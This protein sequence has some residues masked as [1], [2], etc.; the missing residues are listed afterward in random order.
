MSV[1]VAVWVSAEVL[2]S[3]CGVRGVS[4]GEGQGD[5]SVAVVGLFRYC[6][7]KRCL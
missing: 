3:A 2:C 4:A 6:C 1:A 7:L 5:S